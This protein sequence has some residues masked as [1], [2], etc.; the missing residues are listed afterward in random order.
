M[1]NRSSTLHMGGT[2]QQACSP[3]GNQRDRKKE[4]RLVSAAAAAAVT[5]SACHTVE[6]VLLCDAPRLCHPGLDPANYGQKPLQ[7]KLK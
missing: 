5:P 6:L 2:N 4:V 7:N 1:D 3:D